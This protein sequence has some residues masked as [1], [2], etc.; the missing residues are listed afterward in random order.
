MNWWG[1]RG[2]YGEFG[3]RHSH[4]GIVGNYA[5][6]LGTDGLRLPLRHICA[7]CSIKPMTGVSFTSISRI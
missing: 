1:A 5:F 4:L 7:I 2:H 6:F 3:D